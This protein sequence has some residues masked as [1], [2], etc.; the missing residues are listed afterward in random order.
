[1]PQAIACAE[2]ALAIATETNDSRLRDLAHH[3]LMFACHD[4]ADFRRT[5][6]II[7]LRLQDL[8]PE[9]THVSIDALVTC[10]A[11]RAGC[12]LSLGNF[13]A[14]RGAAAEALRIAE[15]WDSDYFIAWAHYSGGTVELNARDWPAAIAALEKALQLA[16]T[17]EIGL[18]LPAAAS[19]LG[20]AYVHAKHPDAGISLLEQAVSQIRVAGATM[21]IAIYEY[22]L[23][24]GYF[25]VGRAADARPALDRAVAV[26]NARGERTVVAWAM[27]L[28]GEIAL[29]ESETSKAESKFADA[30]A[31]ATALG[32]QPL[33]AVCRTSLAK[34]ERSATVS[35][36]PARSR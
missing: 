29:A 35:R 8:R 26:A 31:S 32:L 14:A 10:H 25:L 24:E 5:L 12:H 23:A 4:H 18:L 7:E 28:E 1:L 13:A 22:R 16:R 33:V 19:A 9:P 3:Y 17:G 21:W 30:M 20:L 11:S 34:G 2:Q 15:H 27:W 36:L 6:Q